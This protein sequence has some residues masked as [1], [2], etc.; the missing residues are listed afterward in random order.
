ME[1]KIWYWN[2]KFNRKK[3]DD[4]SLKNIVQKLLKIKKNFRKNIKKRRPNVDE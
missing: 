4:I 2:S 3:K 1:R